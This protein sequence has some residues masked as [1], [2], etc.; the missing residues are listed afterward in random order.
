MVEYHISCTTPVL[1]L[2]W[3]SAR[4]ILPELIYPYKTYVRLWFGILNVI[5]YGLYVFNLYFKWKDNT[6]VTN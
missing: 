3:I 4:H 1:T 2:V 6:K 5:Y